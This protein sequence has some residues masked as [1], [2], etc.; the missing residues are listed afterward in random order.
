VQS[1]VGGTKIEEWLDNS[2][3]SECKKEALDETSS[4]LN[5][6]MVAPFVNMTVKGWLWYQGE[7]NCG[8]DAGNSADKEGYGCEQVSLVESWRKSWSASAGTTEADAPFGI[9]GLAPDS[10]EG[11]GKN[12]ANIRWSQTANYGV[13]PNKALPKTF[14]AQAYDLAD[15]WTHR[16]ASYD[17]HCAQPDAN[18]K[19][20]KGCEWDLSKWDDQLKVVAPG[21]RTNKAP[22][23]MGSIHPRLKYPVGHRLATLAMAVAYGGKGPISGPTI[24]GCEVRE[25]RSVTHEA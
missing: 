2:T 9:V 15:P 6:G 14:I 4:I 23:F 20:G 1:A 12:L 7:N 8:D 19:Y 17:K 3:K 5:Y 11:S 16:M 21:V 10:S 13:L 18:G 22:I 25:E 24:S